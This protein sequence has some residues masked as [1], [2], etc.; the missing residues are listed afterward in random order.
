MTDDDWTGPSITREF[1]SQQRQLDALF[2]SLNG[3]PTRVAELSERVRVVAADT[4]ECSENIKA[5]RDDWAGDKKAQVVER[6]TDR[7]WMVGTA[8]TSAA[9]IL[10]AL[11]IYVG[12]T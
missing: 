10:S 3:M 4:H 2:R 5:L 7:R 9:L 6:K 12:A 1:A 11:G 8:F